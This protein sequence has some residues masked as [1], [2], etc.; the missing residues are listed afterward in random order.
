MNS[1]CVF[2]GKSPL[3]KDEIAIVKKLISKDTKEFYCINCF[4]EYLEI[5]VCDIEQK[6][7]QFKDDGCVLFQ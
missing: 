4:A 3:T 1:E 2:C 5:D 7:E 6:I